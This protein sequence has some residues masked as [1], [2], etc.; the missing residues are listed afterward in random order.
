MEKIRVILRGGSP[1]L[2][3][4]MV[5]ALSQ[6]PSIHPVAQPNDPVEVSTPIATKA[7][8]VLILNTT[9]PSADVRALLAEYP[10]LIPSE[11][12]IVLTDRLEELRTTLRLGVGGYG[13]SEDLQPHDLNIAVRT[14]AGGWSWAC[15]RTLR[16]LFEL[17]GEQRS[18]LP[19]P[20]PRK[21]PISEQELAVLRLAATGAREGEI[22]SKLF[23]SPNTVKTYLRRVR[24]KLQAGSRA[25]AIQVASDMGLIIPLSEDA[26]SPSI[27]RRHPA[28]VP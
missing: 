19:P 21:M 1:L 13:I 14:I 18:V 25:E 4:G 24:Q 9:A 8:D 16:R 2:Q 20:W 3:A 28:R 23:L 22:A 15:P 12:M 26:P 7:A 11:R 27:P 10:A 5:A 17:V 6:D